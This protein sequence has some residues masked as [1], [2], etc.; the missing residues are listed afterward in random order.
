MAH[1]G[2]YTGTYG[3]LRSSDSYPNRNRNRNRNHS[4]NRNRNRNP[5]RN[6]NRN[7]TYEV[8]RLSP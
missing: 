5:N 2:L 4:R 7:P 8:L 1:Y 3:L 6:R